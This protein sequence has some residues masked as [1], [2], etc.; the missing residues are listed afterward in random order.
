VTSDASADAVAVGRVLAGD[1]EAYTELVTRYRARFGRYALH[2]LGN[3]EDAEE[4]LQDAF[5]RAYR[6]LDRCEDPTRFGA[7]FFSILANRCR[8]AGV[9][10]ARRRAMFVHDEVALHNAAEEHPAEGRARREE[11][12]RALAL[13][14]P[15]H[16]EAF[17]MKYVE[18]MGYDEMAGLTGVGVSALKMRVKRACD[19]LRQLLT[20]VERV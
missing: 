7:W 2:M 14:R 4:V 16:R 12:R 5:V 8:T 10:R 18:D 15:E 17:L 9:R 11:I 20:E 13:L 3:R 6:S 1:V 19:R